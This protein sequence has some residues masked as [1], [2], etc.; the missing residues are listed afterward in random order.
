MTREHQLEINGGGHENEDSCN[1]SSRSYNIAC[2]WFHSFNRWLD[3]A[4]S[5][6]VT[7]F[8]GGPLEFSVGKLTEV[9]PPSSQV[10]Y[11]MT[12]R[13]N[14]WRIFVFSRKCSCGSFVKDF[15]LSFGRTCL[16]LLCGHIVQ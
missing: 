9:E 12:S 11:H 7:Y 14:E 2:H 4:L 1:T 5:F 13:C 8:N 10:S 3:L 6:S 15:S 16:Q